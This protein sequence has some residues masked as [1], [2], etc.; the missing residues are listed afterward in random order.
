MPNYNG[1]IYSCKVRTRERAASFHNTSPGFSSWQSLKAVFVFCLIHAKIA[2]TMLHDSSLN[3]PVPGQ[4]LKSSLLEKLKFVIWSIRYFDIM[5]LMAYPTMGAIF[6]IDLLELQNSFRLTMFIFFN[7]LFI[8]HIYIYNDLSDALL[9][10]DEPKSR[11][12]HALKHPAL[13]E[14]EVFTLS[15]AMALIALIGFA[16]ISWRLFL[17]AL[18]LEFL[19]TLYSSSRVNF[20]GKPVFSTLIHFF[21]ASLY[22]MGGWVVFESFTVEGMCLGIFFGLV[23]SAGHFSNEIEDFE[24]DLSAGIRTN[25]IVFGQRPVFRAGLFL[26]LIS[27]LFFLYICIFHL[28][29]FAYIVVCSFLVLGWLV[30]IRRYWHWKGGDGI[31]GFR[32]FY[33]VVY[34]GLCFVLVLIRLTEWLGS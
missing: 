13:S 20:K 15:L 10:P 18:V 4:N 30:Q 2:N 11:S 34:A 6:A 8:A 23:L 7:F 32:L 26:F 16:L 29:S 21:G 12:T 5:V 22:F 24:Q 19:T 3:N 1:K 25:A 31:R 28:G 33:R 14:R 27:S 9:N 17:L